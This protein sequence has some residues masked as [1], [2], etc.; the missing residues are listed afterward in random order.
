MSAEQFRDLLRGRPFKPFRLHVSD[1]TQYVVRH[2]EMANLTYSTV[3]LFDQGP[4][5]KGIAMGV[6]ILSLN[7]IVRVEFVDSAAPALST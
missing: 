2:P 6:E 3:F 4:S 5:G 1:G 7:H